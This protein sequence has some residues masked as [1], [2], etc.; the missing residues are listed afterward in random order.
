MSHQA[1]TVRGSCLCGAI[2]YEVTAAPLTMYHCHCGT[3]RKASGAS[4]ATNAIVPA[5]GFAIVA[6]REALTRYESSPQ[7]YRYFCARCG[8]PI[9]SQADRTAQ[10]VS[11]RC[12]TLD[13]DPGVRPSL[14]VHVAAKASWSEIRDDLP[15]RPEGVT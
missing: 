8:S 14:H 3:C 15:Q 11:V 10:V 4:L 7:K 13:G 12:G 2:V 6:G 9:Y 1:Q 5:A